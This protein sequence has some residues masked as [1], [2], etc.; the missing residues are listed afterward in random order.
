MEFPIRIWSKAYAPTPDTDSYSVQVDREMWNQALH[1][2]GS[3]RKF[4]RIAH[5]EG[6]DDWIAP[7]GDPVASTDSSDSPCMNI[8]MPL[9]MIDAGTFQGQGEESTLE[10]VDEEYFPEATR[11]TL[12]VVDSAF[13]NADVKEELERALSS[14]GVVRQ[15]TTLQIPIEALGGYT[16]EVFL[17]KTE[18]ANLV[19]CH[20]EEV[21]V[22]FEEPVDQ[23]AVPSHSVPSHSVP[24]H[25]VPSHSVPSH[26]VPS[27]SV[28]SRPLTPVPAELPRM[29]PLEEAEQGFR[30]FQGQ[31]QT[32][33]GSNVSIPEWRK[34]LP[35]PPRR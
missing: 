21:A 13:Y 14:L 22:E 20:G 4:L 29:V 33:G 31:G 23:I 2:E 16:V 11:I 27:H 6:L 18:P 1:T 15:H 25:S 10:V 30:A 12:R 34:G 24:S 9:W 3:R 28:P 19:L 5:P 35:P 7:L 32:L 17:S 8:Y 26:S